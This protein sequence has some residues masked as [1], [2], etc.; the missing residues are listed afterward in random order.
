MNKKL[1]ISKSVTFIF[2][3]VYVV[4]FK[5]IFGDENSLVGVTTIT[6]ALMFLGKDLTLSP[7]R[8][9]SRLILLNLFIGIATMLAASN[10][11]LG[12]II[13]FITLFIISYLLCYNLESPMYFP[14]TLQYLFLLSSPVSIEQIPKRLIALAFGGIFVIILQ[15]IVNKN[16]IS[17]S[18][19]KILL[20]VCDSILSRIEFLKNNSQKDTTNDG[21]EANINAFRKMV[22]DKREVDYYLT[23]EGRIKLNLSVALENIY[24]ILSAVKEPLNVLFILNK[25]ECLTHETKSILEGKES[26]KDLYDDMNIFLSECREK[27]IDDLMTLQILDSTILL[28]DAMYELNNLKEENYNLVKQ[29]ES[30]PQYK[31]DSLFRYMRSDH[32]SFRF[33][34][35]MRVAITITLGA[36]ITDFFRL[37]EGRWI[38]FTI[39]SLVN[40]LYEVSKSKVMHRVI[41]TILGGILVTVLFYIFEDMTTRTIILMLAGYI[42]SYISQYK[43]NMILV[44]VSAIGSAAMVGNVGGLT[45]SRITFVV[46]GALMAIIANKYIFP[47]KLE[48]S[49]KEL[50]KIHTLSVLEMLREIYNV[51]EGIKK[52]HSIKNLLIV[53]SLV[54]EKLKLNNQILHDSHY[55]ELVKERRFLVANI[56]ELYIWIIR[57]KVKPEYVKYVL[58]EINILI[59]YED[60]PI[61]DMIKD[62]EKNIKEIKDLNTKITLSSIAIILKELKQISALK[63]LV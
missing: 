3:V 49:N 48:D 23:E 2:V 19:N 58:S 45:L 47:Y 25:L 42:N 12:I 7:V 32:K 26:E 9:A 5:L 14:F 57:A 52:P 43:Y 29:V 6:A 35:A 38:M 17:K 22:Y 34:Y 20:N 62:I 50:E 37:S 36:F 40:P 59:S 30:I 11:W 39:L 31:N 61:E 4:L 27:N 24:T 63:K 33:C 15:L 16:R 13:N 53:T 10:I 56:Y 55:E 8:N 60:E 21:I 46:I 41:A 51:A 28:V 18:G 1:V 54:E 44:T